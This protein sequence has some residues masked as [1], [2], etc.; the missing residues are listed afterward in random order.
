MNFGEQV[1]LLV[2]YVPVKLPVTYVRTCKN[3]IFGIVSRCV[4]TC[5]SV[6]EWL[7]CQNGLSSIFLM[8]S[9]KVQNPR[10]ILHILCPMPMQVHRNWVLRFSKILLLVNM[11]AHKWANFDPSNMDRAGEAS[12]NP[13]RPGVVLATIPVSPVT[14]P[15][16]SSD[17]VCMH[18]TVSAL[19]TSSSL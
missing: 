15:H 4:F 14:A 8:K 2:T 13:G 5:C 12:R 7:T 10:R 16:G 6:L 17:N 3:R 1:Q 19:P 18:V 9:T 11:H